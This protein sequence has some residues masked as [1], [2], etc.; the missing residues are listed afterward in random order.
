MAT[1]GESEKIEAQINKAD[2]SYILYDRPMY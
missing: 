2:V 1:N